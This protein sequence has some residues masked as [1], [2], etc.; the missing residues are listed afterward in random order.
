MMILILCIDENDNETVW[1]VGGE[2]KRNI[3]N[4]GGIKLISFDATEKGLRYTMNGNIMINMEC[5][6]MQGPEAE[7]IIKQLQ[8]G[9]HPEQAFVPEQIFVDGN[10]ITDV[11]VDGKTYDVQPVTEELIEMR[12]Y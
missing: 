11:C 9:K 3:T 8:D 1:G 6:P 4:G 10:V 5:N 12:D 2:L 7:K